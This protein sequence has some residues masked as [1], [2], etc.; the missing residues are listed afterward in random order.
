MNEEFKDNIKK[1]E[2]ELADLIRKKEKASTMKV[3]KDELNLKGIND[4]L[5]EN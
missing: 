1:Y 5:K 3:Q 2:K 4:K